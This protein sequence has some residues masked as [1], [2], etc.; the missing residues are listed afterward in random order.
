MSH[1]WVCFPDLKTLA[2]RDVSLHRIVCFLNKFVAISTN[3]AQ[4]VYSLHEMV[5]E[6]NVW[7]VF[8]SSSVDTLDRN[9]PGLCGRVKHYMSARSGHTA[10]ISIPRG[11]PQRYKPVLCARFPGM[12]SSFFAGNKHTG[13]VQCGKKE[14]TREHA[15]WITKHFSEKT[16]EIHVK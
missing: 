11:M 2:E 12:I 8:C 4:Y 5:Q 7:D 10:Q 6:Y 15:S 3:I 16:G 9:I 14:N 1:F 13:Q